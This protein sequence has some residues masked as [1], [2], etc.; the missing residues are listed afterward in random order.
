MFEK[1][2][3]KTLLIQAGPGLAVCWPGVNTLI[4]FSTTMIFIDKDILK[5]IKFC[6]IEHISFLS[7]HPPFSFHLFLP[8][9]YLLCDGL[10]EAFKGLLPNMKKSRKEERLSLIL[11]LP[12]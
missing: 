2:V 8:H 6:L 12:I 5:E 4:I 9:G 1:I 7:Q 11:I 3:H 10:R